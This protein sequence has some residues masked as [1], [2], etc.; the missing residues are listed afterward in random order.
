MTYGIR[1]IVILT[2]LFRVSPSSADPTSRPSGNFE[3]KREAFYTKVGALRWVAYNPSTFRPGGRPVRREDIAE[4]L[5]VLITS[6]VE[7]QRTGICTYSCSPRTGTDAIA[8]V[9]RELGFGGVIQ[10]VW[11]IA[12]PGENAA[13]RR[14]ARDGLIDA[15]CVGNEGLGGRYRWED[16]RRRIRAMRA[17]TALPVSTSEQ[18]EDYGN[19]DLVDPAE[20]DWAYPNIHPVFRGFSDPQKAAEWVHEM[21]GKV[22]RRTPLPVLVHETG[23]PSNGLRHHTPELQQA[24]WRALLATD[25]QR[26]HQVALFELL[27]QPWKKEI[28][29]RVDIGS[30]WG[31]FTADRRPKPV[32]RVLAASL[33]ADQRALG[34]PKGEGSNPKPAGSATG[35]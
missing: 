30:S 25:A 2:L 20:T 12:D 32:V 17:D 3:A 7:P 9:A 14:L 27:D 5:K 15:V 13:A 19:P 11:D 21:A 33:E 8:G 10:G 16:L 1:V 6:G 29:Q 35:P 31:L 4:D 22:A 28:Y 23:W 24:F 34:N 26:T 18:V